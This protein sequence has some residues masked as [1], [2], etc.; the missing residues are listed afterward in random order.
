[1]EKQFRLI[2]LRKKSSIR[3]SKD[4]SYDI[5]NSAELCKLNIGEMK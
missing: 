1:M 2:P 5:C 3:N 4:Y